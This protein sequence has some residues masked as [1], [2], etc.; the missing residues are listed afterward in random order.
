MSSLVILGAGGF[1]GSAILAEKNGPSP[2]KAVFRNQVTD[3]NLILEKINCFTADLL[4]AGSLDDILDEE[5][6]VINTTY[7]KNATLAENLQLINNVIESCVKK[8]V[9]KLIHVSTAVVVGDTKKTV[10]DET[11]K[12]QP[13]TSYER[14]KYAIEQ[15]ILAAIPR[16]LEVII[17]RPTAILGSGGENLKKLAQSLM[18]GNKLI[19]YLRACFFAKRKMHLVPLQKVVKVILH[20]VITD[21]LKNG[22]IFLIS[23]DDDP[24]NN[25]IDVERLLSCALGLP[26]RKFPI[27]SLPPIFLSVLL[28]LKRCSET[29]VNRSYFSQKLSTTGFISVD[30]IS[31][32]IIEFVTGAK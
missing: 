20:L 26:V 16:G 15:R 10:V 13:L 19:N 9:K 3:K 4:I 28:R 1:L 7:I 8:R 31:D 24:K 18:Y 5:D 30:L 25:F 14:V 21:H 12:C 23:S 27:L 17:V 22:S 32:A 2:F 11:T 6:I 29:N